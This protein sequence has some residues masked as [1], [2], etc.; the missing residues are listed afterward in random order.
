MMR[1]K[2]ATHAD[3]QVA[4]VGLVR[5]ADLTGHFSKR[6][7]S[8]IAIADHLFH[9]RRGPR[10]QE[11]EHADPRKWALDGDLELELARDPVG[12]LAERSWWATV[13]VVDDGVE[14]ANAPKACSIRDVRHRKARGLDQAP[15]EARASNARHLN[16][17][18]SQV[19]VEK[20]PKLA[21][22]NTEA[23]AQCI[24]V[25]VVEHAILD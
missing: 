24:D 23:L 15:R 21:R 20:P 8:V 4:D 9:S 6:R 17:R 7:S 14:S 2:R 5:H 18:R 19:L 3:V 13:D 12:H 16:R 22:A 10:L 25:R 1:T 11:L